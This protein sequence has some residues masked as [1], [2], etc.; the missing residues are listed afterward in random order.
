MLQV[1]TRVKHLFEALESW[2]RGDEE[3]KNREMST[4]ESDGGIAMTIDEPEAAA[5]GKRAASKT[6]PSAA[7]G[8][9]GDEGSRNI[10]TPGTQDGKR[11]TT[12]STSARY[13]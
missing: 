8:V 5:C 2:K 13:E 9:E 7:G 11:P 6:A 12:R 3:E 1:R 10:P 4:G